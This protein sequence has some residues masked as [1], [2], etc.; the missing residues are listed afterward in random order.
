MTELKFLSKFA[1]FDSQTKISNAR[2]LKERLIQMYA[3]T[4]ATVKEQLLGVDL[5]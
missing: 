4:R 3:T 1:G 2:T 5:H